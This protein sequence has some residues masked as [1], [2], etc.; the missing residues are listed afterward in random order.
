MFGIHYRFSHLP[1]FLP[2]AR[3]LFSQEKTGHRLRG[4]PVFSNLKAT[5]NDREFIISVR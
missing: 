3:H 5:I 1:G 2:P 4:R